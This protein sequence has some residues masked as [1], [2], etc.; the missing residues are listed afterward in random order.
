MTTPLLATG[1]TTSSMDEVRIVVVDDFPDA[2]ALLAS[3]LQM[4]GYGVRVAHDGAQ[5]LVV[6]EEFEPHCVLLD[7]D[8]PGLDGAE[9]SKR[10]RARFGD[11]VVL[12]AV[13]GGGPDDPRVA[14]TFDRVDH[15]LTKP[16]NPAVLR[17]I[18]PPL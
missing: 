16:V 12:I 15:Y 7:V 2:A 17:K 9:L 14:E 1:R 5:A 4:D 3:A 11:D 6:I 10:L 18:L 8:M 13:T